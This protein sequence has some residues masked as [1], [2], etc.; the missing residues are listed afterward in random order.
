MTN[1][2]RYKFLRTP[3]GVEAGEEVATNFKIM[4]EMPEKA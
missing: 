3:D 1:A 2:T 4:A